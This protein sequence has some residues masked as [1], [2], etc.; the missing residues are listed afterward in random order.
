LLCGCASTAL[1]HKASGEADTLEYNRRIP[2][3]L[4]EDYYGVDKWDEVKK[5]KYDAYVILEGSAMSD[6]SV[7]L[8]RI[9]ESYPDDSHNQLAVEF[10]KGVKTASSSVSSRISP[11]VNMYVIFMRLVGSPKKLS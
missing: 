7:V 10:C 4:I 8:R 2:A 5:E 1:T 3:S 11:S 6:H 9:V